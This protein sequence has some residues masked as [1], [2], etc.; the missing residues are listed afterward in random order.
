MKFNIY[1]CEDE[2]YSKEFEVCNV[3]HRLLEF[4]CEK[5]EVELITKPEVKGHSNGNLNVMFLDK[6]YSMDDD[7]GKYFTN[8]NWFELFRLKWMFGQYWVQKAESQAQLAMLVLG[9]L[10]GI[11][12]PFIVEKLDKPNDTQLEQVQEVS[13]PNSADV[14]TTPLPATKSD[15]STAT[16]TVKERN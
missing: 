14:S 15:S 6:K 9:Y 10:L 1:Y 7:E 3:K 5:L 12:T 8:V 11:L 4:Q 2:G 16:E 13:Q